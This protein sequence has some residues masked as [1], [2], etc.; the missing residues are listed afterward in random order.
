MK[1]NIV[2]IGMPG[3]GKSTLGVILAKALMM[4][5]VDSDL[6]IQKEEGRTLSRIIEEEGT[7]AFIKTEE[8]INAALEAE[9]AVI[10]TGGSAVYGKQAMEHL[11]QIGTVVYLR[12]SYD[13]VAERLRSL[14]ER[15]VVHKDGQTLK[16]IYNERSG[17][18]EKYADVTVDIDG[19][20]IARALAKVM[21]ALGRRPAAKAQAACSGNRRPAA[22]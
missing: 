19:L 6:V 1:K 18:Y 21:E 9:N 16:D 3:A 17:L 14:K 7:D 20:D 12:I 5:F 22:K 8:R 4:D 13:Q 11:S 15:G 10:A 2:L